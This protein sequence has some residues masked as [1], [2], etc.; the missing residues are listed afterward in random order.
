MEKKNVVTALLL[1]C[2]FGYF[3]GE[4][5]EL[6]DASAYWPKLICL[7]GLALSLL[8]TVIEAVKWAVKRRSQA[9]LNP[10]T[11]VQ[12][13]RILFLLA[14]MILW[15]VGLQTLGFLTSSLVAVIAVAVAYDPHKSAARFAIDVVCCVFFGIACYMLFRYLGIVFP[16]TQLL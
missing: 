3:Y 5:D 8:Q 16:A 7:A 6:M 1:A 11:A 2:V 12:W 9:S 14:V 4:C 15:I 10:F 13:K